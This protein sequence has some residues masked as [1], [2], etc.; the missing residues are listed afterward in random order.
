MITVETTNENPIG[1]ASSNKILEKKKRE[2]VNIES[3]LNFVENK[4]Y[5]NIFSNKIRLQYALADWKPL[6]KQ[7]I[8]VSVAN[9]YIIY[10]TE[11]EILTLGKIIEI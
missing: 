10:I 5:Q 11:T 7:K 4:I 3:I 2:N 9:D 1:K 8:A 6:Y